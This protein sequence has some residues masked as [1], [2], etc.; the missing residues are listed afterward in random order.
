MLIPNLILSLFLFGSIADEIGWRGY[1]CL[2]Q[3]TLTA[4]SQALPLG[5]CGFVAAS[6][7]LF[8]RPGGIK[9]VSYL[10][11]YRDCGSVHHFDLITNS[12]KA[13]GSHRLNGVYR[14]LTQFFLP[15]A[16][17][18]GS[19]VVFQQLYAGALVN[20]ALII[21]LFCGGKTLVFSYR[22]E[23]PASAE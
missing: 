2:G 22:L 17:A 20:M 1:L 19:V 13:C 8:Q 4:V 5:C 6:D 11:V 10:V 14:T 7:L 15:L 3:Q 16:E 21:L 12:S 23:G 18:A 9:L